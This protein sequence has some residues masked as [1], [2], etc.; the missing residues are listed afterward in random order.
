M[1]S[2]DSIKRKVERMQEM[3]QRIADLGKNAKKKKKKAPQE[4]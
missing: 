3:R 1:K 4:R 2:K